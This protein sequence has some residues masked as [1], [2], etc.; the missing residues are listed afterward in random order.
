MCAMWLNRRSMNQR[1]ASCAFVFLSA[2]SW[3]TAAADDGSDLEQKVDASVYNRAGFWCPESCRCS[4][5]ARIVDCSG[6]GLTHVPH[7]ASSTT[8]L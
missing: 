5:T 8:R 1:S 4:T 2:L 7:L 6:R 3:F